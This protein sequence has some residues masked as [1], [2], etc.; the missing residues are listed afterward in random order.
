MQTDKKPIKCLVKIQ[1]PNKAM[2][3][4]EDFYFER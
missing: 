2:A 3:L 1:L 4:K